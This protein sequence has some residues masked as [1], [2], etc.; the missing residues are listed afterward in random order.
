MN[1]FNVTFP[2]IE[3]I[4]IKIVIRFKLILFKKA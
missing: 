4:S 1:Y 3:P 2:F